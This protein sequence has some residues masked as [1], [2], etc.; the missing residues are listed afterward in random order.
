MFDNH[1]FKVSI[2]IDTKGGSTLKKEKIM[3]WPTFIGTV[4][5]LLLAV[6]PMMA[7]PSASEKVITDI[8]SAISIL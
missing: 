6:I 2:F 5:I 7:F 8:N 1:I 4:V 3:D